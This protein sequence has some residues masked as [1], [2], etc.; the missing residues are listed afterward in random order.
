[1]ILPNDPLAIHSR[2]GSLCVGMGFGGWNIAGRVTRFFTKPGNRY[3]ETDIDVEGLNYV[4]P[5][6]MVWING[7]V[8]QQGPPGIYRATA[9]SSRQQVALDALV[10]PPSPSW[11]TFKLPIEPNQP[12]SLRFAWEGDVDTIRYHVYH[13]TEDDYSDARRMAIYSVKDYILVENNEDNGETIEVA[14]QDGVGS[15]ASHYTLTIIKS[16]EDITVQATNEV[17][18]LVGDT[19]AWDGL[20]LSFGSGLSVTIP[21]TYATE[22]TTTFDVTVGP[23]REFEMRRILGDTHHFQVRSERDDGDISAS[24]WVSI[25]SD[26]PPGQVS[27]V[28]V[29]YV[30]AGEIQVAFTLPSDADI[31]GARVYLSDPDD[32]GNEMPFTANSVARVTGTPSQAKTLNIDDLDAG[33]YTMMIRAYDL[34]GLDDMSANFYKF[35]LTATAVSPSG[36]KAPMSIN[37]ET[38]GVGEVKIRVRVG[39]NGG[40]DAIWLFSDDGA[41]GEVDYDNIFAILTEKSGGIYEGTYSHLPEGTWTFAARAAASGVAE[42]NVT[43]RNQAT[44]YEYKI[45]VPSNLS[46][47]IAE[48]IT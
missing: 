14:G 12:P 31:A 39:T 27:G 30:A 36:L 32:T 34:S 13:A 28:S 19:M 20:A 2:L 15:R 26:V 29:S 40:E 47:E 46:V 1:M 7:T 33:I 21:D 37:V 10:L 24:T 3:Y 22:G 41:G 8:L 16:G 23:R 17:T 9:R 18:G 43:V 35:Q 4:D 25:E 45:S 44:V 48:G 6:V 11:R 42:P 5:D 38:I